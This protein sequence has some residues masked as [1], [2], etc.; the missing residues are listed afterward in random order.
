MARKWYKNIAVCLIIC[1]LSPWNLVASAAAGEWMEHEIFGYNSSLLFISSP[2]ASTPVA[3]TPSQSIQVGGGSEVSGAGQLI[4]SR[5]M[6]LKELTSSL[7]VSLPTELVFNIDLYDALG[8]GQIY[9]GDYNFQNFSKVDVRIKLS[10]IYCEFDTPNHFQSLESMSQMERGTDKK[11]IYLYFEQQ[12]GQP[13]VATPLEAETKNNDVEGKITE[14]ELAKKVLN[15]TVSQNTSLDDPNSI[16]FSEEI[17]GDM[18]HIADLYHPAKPGVV[19]TNVSE[20]SGYSFILSADPEADNNCVRFRLTG[21]VNELS[22]YQWHSGEIKIKAEFQIEP[23]IDEALV[24]LDAQIAAAQALLDEEIPDEEALYI[25]EIPDETVVRQATPAVSDT[26]VDIELIEMSDAQTPKQEDVSGRDNIKH[27]EASDN[28]AEE[29]NS[30]E[31]QENAETE[32]GSLDHIEAVNT[33]KGE[34]DSLDFDNDSKEENDAL[35]GET[36]ETDE[37]ERDL[38]H[39]QEEEKSQ[40][41]EDN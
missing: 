16:N 33:P 20:E 9:S 40:R 1:L 17:D 30:T 11:Q 2:M 28:D 31:A 41:L 15:Q 32:Y 8:K 12:N 10:R 5:E 35:P 27:I 24:E 6:L 18:A 37:K 23:M 29:T 4:D 39:K 19:I 3:S 21:A 38:E 14:H 36:E 7:S 13:E 25:E 34:S 22:R 26:A